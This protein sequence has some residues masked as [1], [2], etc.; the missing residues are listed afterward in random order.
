MI[1]GLADKLF[2]HATSAA[3]GDLKIKPKN[4]N[5]DRS[6]NAHTVK[7]FTDQ[8]LDD[9]KFDNSKVKVAWILESPAYFPVLHEKLKYS[10]HQKYF[11]YILTS[12]KSL[13]ENN[14]KFIFCPNGGT[15]IKPSDWKIYKKSKML[16]I[17]ASG[18][19]GMKGHKLRNGVLEA[20]KDKMDVYGRKYKELE[21]KIDGIKPYRYQIVIENCKEDYYFT[22]KLIDCFATGTVPIY[23]GCPSI[24]NFFDIGG[25]IT[26]DS[27]EQLGEIIQMLSPD[28]Y[29]SR[30]YSVKINLEK[31]KEFAVIEDYIGIK[32][33]PEIVDTGDVIHD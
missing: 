30:L 13:L 17:I 23:W 9:A 14:K 33:L 32:I 4:L 31:A 27:I 18:K 3:N 21:N 7:F 6:S 15:W 25:I 1:V 8:S 12:S 10:H 5:F 16:S 19:D 2:D 11:N 29:E 24:G 22:E 26:F 28:D 20:Y